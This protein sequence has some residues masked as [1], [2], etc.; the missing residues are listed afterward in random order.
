MLHAN[1]PTA[2]GIREEYN[3]GT[4]TSVRDPGL[5]TGSRTQGGV[6]VSSR[7]IRQL[8]EAQARKWQFTREQRKETVARVH[9]LITISRQH[10]TAAA[11]IGERVA[12]RLGYDFWDQSIVHEMAKHGKISEVLLESLDEHPRNVFVDG[13]AAFQQVGTNTSEYMRE[14]WF[15]LNAIAHHGDAVIVGRG[16]QYTVDPAKTLRVRLIAPIEL[17]AERLAARL[18][19]GV[20]EARA[21]ID[22]VESERTTFVREQW[23]Q[24]IDDVQAYDLIVNLEHLDSDAATECIVTAHNHRFQRP[25]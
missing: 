16:A 2:V 19:V 4:R 10:G 8:A 22:R 5:F 23:S 25:S 20:A 9:P 1:V 11:E 18:G 15:Q 12:E 7:S 24:D 3:G 14:L 17:R 13:F 21:R 6:K